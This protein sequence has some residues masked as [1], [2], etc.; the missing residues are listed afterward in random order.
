M[1]ILFKKISVYGVYAFKRI[2]MFPTQSLTEE[3]AQGTFDL[4]WLITF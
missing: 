2:L 3:Y 4:I 1:L